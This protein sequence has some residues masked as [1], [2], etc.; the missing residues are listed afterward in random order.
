[1]PLGPWCSEQR[2]VLLRRYS[3]V[4]GDMRTKFQV[5]DVPTFNLSP[6]TWFRERG[7]S[8]LAPGGNA[9]VAMARS[10]SDSHCWDALASS[11]VMLLV[12]ALYTVLRPLASWMAAAS[13]GPVYAPS[14]IVMYAMPLPG[15]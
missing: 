10:A 2:S 1:M 14:G 9:P 13:D 15:G 3:T 8:R 11:C 4:Y 5:T 7:L 6:S 12:C